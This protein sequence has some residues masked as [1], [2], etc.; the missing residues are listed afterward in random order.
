MKTYIIE[1]YR[2]NEEDVQITINVGAGVIIRKNNDSDIFE[3]LLIQRAEDDKWPLRWEIPRGKC[4]KGSGEKDEGVIPCLKRE[5][6]EETGLDIK[7]IKFIDKFQYIADNGKR[8]STQ[9]NFL[10]RLINPNQQIQLSKEHQSFKW[11][12]TMAEVQL[13]TPS[14]EIVTTVSKVF[15]VNG[16]IVNYPEKQLSIEETIKRYLKSL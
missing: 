15:D 3:L 9:Y 5:V 13:L 7:P 11:V 4:D 10:C 1:D 8:R 16:E 6:K 14:Q 2:G 12:K